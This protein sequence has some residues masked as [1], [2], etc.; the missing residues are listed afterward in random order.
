M[1]ELEE[2]QFESTESLLASEQY[3]R[4]LQSSGGASDV[5]LIKVRVTASQ[6]LLALLPVYSFPVV[7]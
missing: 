4:Q 2:D 1:P 7:S 6:C 3:N 5:P